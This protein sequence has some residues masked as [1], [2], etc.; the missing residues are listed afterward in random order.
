M[1]LT[2]EL[3][4]TAAQVIPVFAVANALAYNTRVRLLNRS[5]KALRKRALAAT[6]IIMQ[7][8]REGVR[9]QQLLDQRRALLAS[10]PPETDE[11]GSAAT[12]SRMMIVFALLA[13]VLA[14]LLSFAVSL[15]V[16]G[17]VVFDPGWGTFVV[18]SIMCGMALS[19]ILPL[20]QSRF[21]GS[22]RLLTRPRFW[23]ALYILQREQYRSL[24]DLNRSKPVKGMAGEG[25][26]AKDA[27]VDDADR[28]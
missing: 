6:D 28:D 7:L 14:N 1:E 4:G 12:F 17:G 22:I 18:T 5:E 23:A 9:G 25:Q 27:G 15:M 19:A 2:L 20:A 21:E 11:V 24:S 16:L 8:H 10:N 3:A 13:T 26:D